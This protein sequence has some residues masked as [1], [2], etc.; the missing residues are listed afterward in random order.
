ML[1]DQFQLPTDLKFSLIQ[2]ASAAHWNMMTV[3]L[4]TVSLGEAQYGLHW[5]FSL[6]HVKVPFGDITHHLPLGL[7]LIASD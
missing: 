3:G 7:N 1:L 5:I 6:I 4:S 2:W